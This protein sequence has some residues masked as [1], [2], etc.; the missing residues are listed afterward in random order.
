MHSTS[1]MSTDSESINSQHIQSLYV[2]VSGL[3]ECCWNSFTRSNAQTMSDKTSK[4]GRGTST[5]V[6]KGVIALL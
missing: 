1:Q 5:E 4:Q 3:R 2:Q 6:F